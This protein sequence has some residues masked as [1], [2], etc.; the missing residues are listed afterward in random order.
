[1]PASSRE[2]AFGM[3]ALGH[4]DFVATSHHFEKLTFIYISSIIELWS[5]EPV[6]SQSIAAA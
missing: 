6:N 5:V 1:M 3:G 4:W 2:F